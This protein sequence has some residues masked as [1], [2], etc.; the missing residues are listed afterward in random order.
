MQLHK[1]LLALGCATGLALVAAIPVLG[2]DRPESILPPGF[3]DS[4]ENETPKQPIRAPE[5][6]RKRPTDLL[7][8]FELTPPTSG[9][10]PSVSAAADGALI[11]EE[12][13][14]ELDG[15]ELPAQLVDIPAQLRRS[16]SI[17]GVLGAGD[18]DMGQA[19]F[20]GNNGQYLQK[21]M[22]NIR[23][24]IA[25]RWASILLRRALLSR[26]RTPDGLN[27]ADWVAERAWL[28]L[29]MGEADAARQLVQSVDVDQFT[30]KMYQVAMQT[31]LATAD[32]SALCAMAEGGSRQLKEPAWPLA[33]A[34]CAGMAG[35][36]SLA[37]SLIDQARD[38]RGQTNFDVLLA[39]KVFGATANT[40]RA[41]V[42]QWDGVDKLTA[43]RFGLASAT[44]LEIPEKLMASSGKHVRAWQARVPLLSLSKRVDAA[45]KAA[46][47]GVLSS[48][49]LV[50]FYGAL[51]EETD[52]P[53]RSGKPFELLRNAYIAPDVDERI[54]AMRTLWTSP[55]SD[56][57]AYSRYLL[58]ARAAARI[59]AT[60]MADKDTS[61]LVA[62]ML[63]AGLDY[64]A[65]RWAPFVSAADSIETWGLMA[66]GSNRLMSDVT[67]GSIANFGNS[68]K[69][70]QDLKS[71]FLFAGLA[72][73]G[74]L[75]A[76]EISEMADQ[77]N[78]AIARKTAWTLALERAVRTNSPASVALLCA[79][80]LQTIAWQDVTPFHLFHIVLSLRQVGFEAEAR[81]IAAEALMRT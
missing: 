16:T 40:R 75:P 17:V 4:D 64:Q 78:V 36:S 37:S 70:N 34:M 50:D 28:L 39:E 25:S 73:L 49:A 81:M 22:R 12:L 18:G 44:G 67:A 68:A 26:T 2:Q 58:T 13:P 79:V 54:A 80:G 35:E 57:Y 42:V 76:G 55:E 30:P 56:Q 23:A 8:D 6:P 5:T 27:G 38:K 48:A 53:D 31:A 69:Q 72:G 65:T 66:V 45:E 61:R 43:W 20:A 33:R 24:P 52:A 41:V 74:R 62:S 21:L 15:E 47:L 77:F 29:R 59:P 3:G 19:G 32:P 10:S 9:Q 14:D 46:E 11:G 51:R 1:G 63:S 60:S 7:P 71:G